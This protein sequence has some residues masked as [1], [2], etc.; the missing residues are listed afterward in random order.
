MLLQPPALP[1]PGRGSS[2]ERTFNWGAPA[3]P[4]PHARHSALQTP[5]DFF[6]LLCLLTLSS[7]RAAAGWAPSGT[8]NWLG[9]S[10]VSTPR[11]ESGRCVNVCYTL[12]TF[13]S[14]MTKKVKK[15]KKEVLLIRVLWWLVFEG[16][17]LKFAIFLSNQKKWLGVWPK[18][19]FQSA[20]NPLNSALKPRLMT[21]IHNV[22]WEREVRWTVGIDHNQTGGP[23]YQMVFIWLS[24]NIYIITFYEKI[25]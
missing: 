17:C 19:V 9:L 24:C 11:A 12:L 2:P 18:Y 5:C 22:Y 14:L 3:P 4:P 6:S 13:E 7:L 23:Q 20:V 15:K 16:L 21:V 25:N 1:R 8:S 10:A